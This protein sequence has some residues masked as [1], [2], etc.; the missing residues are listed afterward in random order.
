M[1]DDSLLEGKGKEQGMGDDASLPEVTEAWNKM[2]ESCRPT[3]DL[4]PIQSQH[5]LAHVKRGFI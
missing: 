4:L 2:A 5:G 3:A 1:S